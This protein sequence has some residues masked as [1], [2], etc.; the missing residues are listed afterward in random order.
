MLW[1]ELKARLLE[2]GSANLTGEPAERFIAKSAAG[3]GAGGKGSIFFAMG[4][5][6]VKLAISPLSPI[7]VAHRGNGTAQLYFEGQ[8]INGRLLESGFH[9]PD[10]AFVTVTGSCIYHCRYCNVPKLQGKRKSIE[11]IVHMVESVKNRIHAISITSGV[12]SSIEEEESYVLSVIK[13]LNEF[14]L[15]I[16]VSIYPTR[17]TPD[18]LFE[19]GVIEVKFNLE[20]AT[21]ELFSNVCPGLD[22]G[23]L[24]EVLD[25]SVTL[26]GRGRVFSNIIMGIGET[27]KELETCIHNLVSRGIIPVLRPLNP[28][29]E[30][31]GTPRPTAQRLI[32]FYDLLSRELTAAKLDPRLSLTMCSNCTGCDLVP[33]RDE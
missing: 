26:F 17:Q 9:C 29:A 31:I 24:Q 27:D 32:K 23:Q 6:R 21:A 19:L 15:P 28:V 22:Y 8:L 25:K 1:K 11:E 2:I 14:N 4:S 3:P 7:E 16:G 13:R 12:L 10:Q 33:G 18:R 5:H 30:F 20:A